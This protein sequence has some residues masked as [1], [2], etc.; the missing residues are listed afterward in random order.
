MFDA[1]NEKC[2]HLWKLMDKKLKENVWICVCCNEMR[3]IKKKPWES[4]DF[5]KMYNELV[6]CVLLSK[7]KE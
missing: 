5:E 2:N 7:D 4:V 3:T 6:D 1:K